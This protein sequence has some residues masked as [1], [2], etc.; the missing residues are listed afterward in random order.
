[1]VM[2]QRY[3]RIMPNCIGVKFNRP[4]ANQKKKMEVLPYVK[5]LFCCTIEKAFFFL[6]NEWILLTKL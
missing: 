4:L 6:L 3:R 2:V 5:T 1:M